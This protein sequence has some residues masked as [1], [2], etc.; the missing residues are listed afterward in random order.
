MFRNRGEM[1]NINGGGENNGGFSAP[2]YLNYWNGRWIIIRYDKTFVTISLIATAIILITA[3]CT[4]LFGYKMTYYDPMANIKNQFLTIQLIAIVITI[5][6]A[7]GAIEITKKSKENLIKYLRIIAIISFVS[8]VFFVGI[9][10]YLDGKYNDKA[11][12]MFYN[13]YASENVDENSKKFTIGFNGINIVSTKE[14]YISEN[15]SAY[16]NFTIKVWIYAILQLVIIL[17]IIYLSFRLM[18]IEEKKSKIEKMDNII[19]D[20]VQNV[21]Y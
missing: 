19:Y 14:A 17:L 15:K 4:Y 9:K 6:L 7:V 21:K 10:F 8:I 11:F 1:P 16:T 2:H 18:N 20:D 5:I 12:S 13:E 3:F